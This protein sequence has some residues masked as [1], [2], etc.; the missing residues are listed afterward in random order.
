MC[1]VRL[2]IVVSVMLANFLSYN[3][4]ITNHQSASNFLVCPPSDSHVYIHIQPRPNT[5]VSYTHAQ[6]SG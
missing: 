6:G 3:H 4:L 2:S 1:L 5:Y